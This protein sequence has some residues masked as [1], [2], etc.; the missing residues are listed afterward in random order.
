VAEVS[1]RWW[2]G[3]GKERNGKEVGEGT[4][5][6]G[7]RG[8]GGGGRRGRDK[9]RGG[10]REWSGAVGVSGGRRGKCWGGV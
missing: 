7:G 5:E 3:M 1:R 10:G 4:G 9:G 8:E 6:K 2:N